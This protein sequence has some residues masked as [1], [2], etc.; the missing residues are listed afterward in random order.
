MRAK[1]TLALVCVLV[2]ATALMPSAEAADRS[3]R[4]VTKQARPGQPVVQAR[5]AAAPVRSVA[6]PNQPQ[7][8]QA[9]AAA[10]VARMAA[11]QAARPQAPAVTRVAMPAGQRGHG[12]RIAPQE[13]ARA[14]AA[15]PAVMR[16]AHAS[17]HGTPILPV[18]VTSGLSCVPFARMAT[19]MAI[20]GDAHV[21]WYNAAGVYARGQ[22]PERGSVL[23]FAGTGGMSRGHVA[24]VSRVVNS[25]TIEVDHANWGGPGLRRGQVL[26]GALVVD[27]SD[28]NDWTAVRHQVGFDRDSF[29][30]TYAT[31][32]FI[33]NR[34]ATDGRTIMVRG[35]PMEEVAEATSPHTAQ[36]MRLTAQLFGN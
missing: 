5:P 30:R 12:S 14:A 16:S 19:G 36:H 11:S 8:R 25:R 1:G 2:G 17:G 28:R 9:A 4:Q 35:Q 24:V 27:V 3:S 13:P 29:G 31:H 21:W 18:S 22:T 15:M 33:Y 32:G 10:P 7:A 20:S 26:R 34:S 6:K 23:A